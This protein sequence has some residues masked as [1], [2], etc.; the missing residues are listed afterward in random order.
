MSDRYVDLYEYEGRYGVMMRPISRTEPID[1]SDPFACREL[2]SYALDKFRDYTTPRV[3]SG[4]WHLSD[5]EIDALPPF[6]SMTLPS[7]LV[8]RSAIRY[9]FHDD[10]SIFDDEDYTKAAYAEPIFVDDSTQLSNIGIWSPA[11]EGIHG[12]HYGR[13]IDDRKG[14]QIFFSPSRESN[15][16]H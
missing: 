7:A 6:E 14:K 9:A 12:G 15:D 8:S 1:T 5:D 16:S 13:A 2:I 11:P 3:G 4:R 10:G